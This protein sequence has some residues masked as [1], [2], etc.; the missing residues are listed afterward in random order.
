MVPNHWGSTWDR[1]STT[2]AALIFD[3]MLC[4]AMHSSTSSSS[5][6]VDTVVGEVSKELIEA[7][8]LALDGLANEERMSPASARLSVPYFNF[9]AEAETI[10]EI[11]KP[12]QED[13][14][15]FNLRSGAEMI[16]ARNAH[17][18]TVFKALRVK[19]NELIQRM[20][21]E[22]FDSRGI[23][24]VNR[25]NVVHTVQ[26]RFVA[27]S[28]YKNYAELVTRWRNGREA[29]SKIQQCIFIRSL[30]QAKLLKRNTVGKGG[31]E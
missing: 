15:G 7:A 16:K 14:S 26:K 10:L 22:F 23:F 12:M 27:S 17:N 5:S 24:A 3:Q 31:A 29:P 18:K 4:D 9:T 28:V 25:T 1:D 20:K 13:G 2:R 21:V 19:L 8:S 11:A 30:L 6:R